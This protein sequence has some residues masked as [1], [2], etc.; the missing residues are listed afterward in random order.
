M[1][2]SQPNDNETPRASRITRFFWYCAGADARILEKCPGTDWIKY[3]GMGGIV[4]ATSILA[5]ASGSYAFYT[6][7]E[8]KQTM[9][10]ARELDDFTLLVAIAAGLL[11]ALI[12]FNI[13]RFIVSSSG[14]GDGTE[15]I[16]FRELL[17]SL[18]RLLLATIIGICISAPLEIRILKSEI[19][20]QLELEQN[21]Y[22]GELNRHSEKLIQAR[23]DELRLKV[24]DARGRQQKQEEYFE[25]RRLEINKQRRL[26]ETEA[27][28][29]TA[30]GKSG[31]GPAWR[32][33]KE[34]LDQ[35]LA[36]LE[37][38]R[39]R[40]QEKM[41]A[42]AADIGQWNRQLALLDKEL[43]AAKASNL[44]QARHLD[45]L[46]KRIQISHEI[47]GVVPLFIMLLLLA[48]ETGPVFFKMMLAKSAYD[49][50]KENAARV[51][52]AKAGIEVD[53]QLYIPETNEEIRYTAYHQP[54][55][56]F[57]EEQRRLASEHVLAKLVHERFR[58]EMEKD[59]AT[60]DNY[61]KYI[62][63]GN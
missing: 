53:A 32:D 29:M 54:H 49:Y 28:G 4:L 39:A 51:A 5:F 6:V 12:I 3:Q 11:W 10:L 60:G 57:S 1:T 58:E 8:P 44:Q 23:K 27:E 31:R 36:E 48:I 55:A 30:S 20:A 18:P 62:E 21:E 42:V 47:G 34:T 22:L 50:L 56:V 17:Q 25:S 7:F 61:R 15:R 35:M 59:I 13:D 37:R 19:E 33:K 24:D 52:T 41:G 9:A 26:L 46:M 38:D 16:T 45:G 63:P 14:Q 2:N 43:E 40:D